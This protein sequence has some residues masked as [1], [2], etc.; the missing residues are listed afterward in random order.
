VADGR[1]G[2]VQRALIDHGVDGRASHLMIL[3][4]A[5]SPSLAVLQI[6]MSRSATRDRHH[7]ASISTS[8]SWRLRHSLFSL[9][10]LS[11]PSKKL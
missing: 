1:D 8:G 3:L 7:E 5:R 2:P 11:I 6:S 9:K 10:L 4:A